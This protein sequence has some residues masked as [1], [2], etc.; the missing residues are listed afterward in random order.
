[1]DE[2]VPWGWSAKLLPIVYAPAQPLSLAKV[3]FSN[4]FITKLSNLKKF[5]LNFAHST[6]NHPHK[7]LETI[8]L[9]L[10]PSEIYIFV[11]IL[12]LLLH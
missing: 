2:L 3:I 6:Q 7:L 12:L 1:M 11:S 4:S 9:E 8:I 10:T 5:K